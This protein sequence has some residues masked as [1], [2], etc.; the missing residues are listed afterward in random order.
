MMAYSRSAVWRDW[1]E[2]C[3]W[4]VLK[5]LQATNVAEDDGS[6]IS[7]PNAPGRQNERHFCASEGQ[8]PS[9]AIAAYLAHLRQELDSFSTELNSWSF[10]M[11]TGDHNCRMALHALGHLSHSWQDFYAHAVNRQGPLLPVWGTGA[12]IGNAAEPGTGVRPPIY[13]FPSGGEHGFWSEPA[14]RDGEDGGALR[15]RDAVNFVARQ[16]A[17]L[18]PSWYQKCRCFCAVWWR[19]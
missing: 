19:G 14:D 13:T 3:K 15:R 9:D 17:T 2:N 5:I 7:Y 11:G 4:V 12:S 16:Y 1:N 10:S 18:L 8:L 6:I